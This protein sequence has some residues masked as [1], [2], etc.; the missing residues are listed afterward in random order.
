MSTPMNADDII[1][2]QKQDP[3]VSEIERTH[4]RQ[5]PRTAPASAVTE[6]NEEEIECPQQLHYDLNV[7]KEIIQ[8][9]KEDHYIP[10]MSAT[11]LT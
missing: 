6:D 5:P 3:V 4:N 1:C 10:L 9:D 8:H 7:I 11:T 2:I